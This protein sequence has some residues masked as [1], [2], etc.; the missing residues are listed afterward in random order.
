MEFARFVDG[1][2]KQHP[3][4]SSVSEGDKQAWQLMQAVQEGADCRPCLE[5][6]GP[7][8][9]DTDTAMHLLE[10]AVSTQ[11]SS[12][13]SALLPLLAGAELARWRVERLLEDAVDAAVRSATK[14]ASVCPDKQNFPQA[15][16]AAASKAPQQQDNSSSQRL[17]RHDPDLLENESRADAASSCLSLLCQW[18][19]TVNVPGRRLARFF[20]VAM[21]A[22]HG[23]GAQPVMSVMQQLCSS[24]AAASIR[25]V[26]ELGFLLELA[27]ATRHSACVKLLLQCPA[28]AEITPDIL[29]RLLPHAFT[30]HSNYI[31]AASCKPVD[32]CDLPRKAVN[33]RDEADWSHCPADTISVASFLAGQR[34]QLG[35]VTAEQLVVL[36]HAAVQQQDGPQVAALCACP[37]AAQLDLAVKHGLLLAAAALPTYTCLYEQQQLP[38][39]SEHRPSWAAG[40]GAGA[41][42]GSSCNVRYSAPY[43]GAQDGGT[44]AGYPQPPQAGVA[45]AFVFGAWPPPL[46]SVAPAPCGNWAWPAAASDRRH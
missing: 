43:S 15:A 41:A 9:V 17:Q 8:V 23:S 46:A 1:Y 36:L 31:A 19:A 16:P 11:H 34:W 3:A 38:E 39:D 35:H 42:A 22:T 26:I 25:S 18:D 40:P 28:A 6:P 44:G 45:P 29:G 30:C 7:P 20:R 4:W 12:N 5:G 27:I 32:A 13:V 10:L 14:T 37:A 33:H 2:L 21:R 24:K